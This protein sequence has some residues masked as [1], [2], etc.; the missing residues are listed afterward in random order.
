M[1]ISELAIF[2]LIDFQIDSVDEMKLLSLNVDRF[3]QKKHVK[4]DQLFPEILQ[5]C[6]QMGNC[7]EELPKKPV[8]RLL[9][10]RFCHKHR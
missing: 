9:A 3:T 1:C 4:K 6:T 8:G 2:K 10:H 5:K 7:E